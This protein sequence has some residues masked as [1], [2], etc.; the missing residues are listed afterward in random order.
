MKYKITKAEYD[1]LSDM[2]KGLYKA[3]DND[4]FTLSVEGMP[5]PEDVSGLKEQNAKLLAE[6][7]DALAKQNAA[8][9]AAKKAAED[10]ARASGDVAALD[11]SWK[12]K[13]EEQAAQYEGRVKTLSGTV[14]ELTVGSTAKDIAAKV[15]GKNAPLMMPHVLQRLALEEVDGKHVVRVTKDGKPT[16]STLDELQKEFT[17]NPEYASVVIGTKA[18]GAPQ[19]GALP[20][21]PTIGSLGNQALKTRAMEIAEGIQGAE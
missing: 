1:A 18:G 19:G 15:F 12:A 17:N 7:K 6:K 5:E 10:A 20:V 14:S 3:G 4:S 13:F 8:D 9:A 16:A 11:A 2:Q 21:T